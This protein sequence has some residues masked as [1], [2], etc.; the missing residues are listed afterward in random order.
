MTQL[1]PLLQHEA[2]PPVFFEPFPTMTHP[3]AFRNRADYPYPIR[4]I[5]LIRLFFYETPR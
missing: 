2:L 3:S 4:L 5:R 1:C